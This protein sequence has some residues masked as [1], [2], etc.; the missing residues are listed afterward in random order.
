MLSLDVCRGV[1]EHYGVF[2]DSIK[3]CSSWLSYLLL[4]SRQK[5]LL[6]ILW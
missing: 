6:E 1:S 4:Q 3:I 5:A 2:T